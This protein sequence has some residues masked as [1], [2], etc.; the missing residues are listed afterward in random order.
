ME[1][2]EATAGTTDVMAT[3]T[4]ATTAKKAVAKDAEDAI[5]KNTLYK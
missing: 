5:K 2:V 4:M 1:D 3:A